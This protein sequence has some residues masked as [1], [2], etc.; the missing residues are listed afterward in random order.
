[1]STVDT[2][3]DHPDHDN[4]VPEA[5]MARRRRVFELADGMANLIKQLAVCAD[6]Y[7]DIGVPP[8]DWLELVAD[9]VGGTLARLV[10]II[11][12]SALEMGWNL[13][14]RSDGTSI[15]DVVGASMG[16]GMFSEL[17]AML[18]RARGRDVAEADLDLAQALHPEGE[19]MKRVIDRLFA[20]APKLETAAAQAPA[21]ECF[22]VLKSGSQI[23]GALSVTPEGTLRLLAGNAV[24]GKPV[25]VEYFFDYD[26]VA[27][28]A[29]LREVKA[30][31]GSRI[32]TS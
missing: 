7:D 10:H 16:S 8:T 3:P 27:S 15:S 17:L 18:T 23:Q 30:T 19:R 13:A 28:V 9:R 25:M 21:L 12:T 24:N 22:I 5:E 11:P 29:V 6:A 14:K 20:T 26:Q 31:E 1:M 2:N 32:V 4:V